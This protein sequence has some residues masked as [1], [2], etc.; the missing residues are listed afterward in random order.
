MKIKGVSFYVLHRY[1]VVVIG[2]TEGPGGP[3]GWLLVLPSQ[4][5]HISCFELMC[6]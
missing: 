3:R 2:I 5:Q 6:G 4:V 1:P